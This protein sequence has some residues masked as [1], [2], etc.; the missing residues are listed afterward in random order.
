MTI[1]KVIY[2][3]RFKVTS[4]LTQIPPPMVGAFVAAY[5]L[6]ETPTIAAER[7]VSKFRTMGYIVEDMDP[8]GGAVA[9]AD[10]DKHVAETWPEFVE[11]FPRQESVVAQLETREAIL[12]PFAGYE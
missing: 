9:V 8:K 5:S 12:G 4:G 11:H 7:A 6:G 10:W 3:F 1:A 2:F